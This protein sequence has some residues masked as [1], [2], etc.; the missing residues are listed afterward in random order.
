MVY[1]HLHAQPKGWGIVLLRVLGGIA[2]A[3]GFGFIFGAAV[4]LL[5]NW[6]LPGLFG[7][8]FIGYWQGVGLVILGRLL[9]GSFGHGNPGNAFLQHNQ[10]RQRP[11]YWTWWQ[12]EGKQA[13]QEYIER[14]R[15][16][17]ATDEKE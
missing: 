4:V 17:E 15:Q 6:L 13:F 3:I 14:L 11:D 10:M 5:W 9:F 16:Q 8:K 12:S 7:V 2:I 1:D